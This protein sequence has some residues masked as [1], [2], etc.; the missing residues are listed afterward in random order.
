MLRLIVLTGDAYAS[1]GIEDAAAASGLVRVIASPS[2]IPKAPEVIRI[3]N[4][5]RPELVLLDLTHWEQV[6]PLA[7]KIH[8][9]KPDS[10]LLG[11]RASWTEADAINFAA[12]GVQGLLPEPFTPKQLEEKAFEVLH[13]SRPVTHPDILA[14]LPAK[15]GSGCSTIAMNTAHALSHRLDRKTLLME[16][17]TRAGVLSILLNLKNRVG[18]TDA[19]QNATDLSPVEWT[20]H[21]VQSHGI[22]LLLAHPQRPSALS[23]WAGYYQLLH[24]LEKNYEMILADLPEV[25]N[26]GTAELVRCAREVFVVCT[27][28]VPSLSMAPWRIADLERHGVDPSRIHCIV[29]RWE[30]RGISVEQASEI[31]GR[32][33]Y[34][35]LPN[36]Y[37]DVKDATLECRP[38]RSTSI[39]GRSC[40]ALARKASR[41]TP[42]TGPDHSAPLLQRLGLITS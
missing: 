5:Q 10:V 33:V 30:R 42:T 38:V 27:P 19:L 40:E 29:N 25:I 8:S 34:A 22:D 35:T 9:A 17:D 13:Q 26:T 15:A 18:M 3:L 28:E 1:A 14:F 21:C 31:V 23:T 12:A 37:K 7:R 32:P 2:P 39:L 36:A 11:F 6:E 4:I 16:T 41:F 20:Q 24:F